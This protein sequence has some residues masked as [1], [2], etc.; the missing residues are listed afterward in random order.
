MFHLH[1]LVLHLNNVTALLHVTEPES[2]A[3]EVEQQ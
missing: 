2:W 1:P 3:C